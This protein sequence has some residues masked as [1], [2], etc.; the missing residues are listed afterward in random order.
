[1]PGGHGGAPARARRVTLRMV[2]GLVAALSV[3]WSTWF[4]AGR[5]L[6]P[7]LTVSLR[8]LVIDLATQQVLLGGE[9]LALTA[10]EYA[11]AVGTRPRLHATETATSTLTSAANPAAGLQTKPFPQVLEEY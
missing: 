7:A 1:M 9:P 11:I 3:G 8:V 10:R 4:L 2:P 5:D 6:D